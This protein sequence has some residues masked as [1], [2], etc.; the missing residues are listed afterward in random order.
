MGSE[1]VATR[2]AAGDR[3][4]FRRSGTRPTSIT[5]KHGVFGW[6]LYRAIV[7]NIH[8][9]PILEGAP[10]P[11][12]VRCSRRN[13]FGPHCSTIALNNVRR[14]ISSASEISACR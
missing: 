9:Q 5:S 8:L 7:C 13:L 2:L 12:R 6:S 11:A 1:V 10:S 3:R 4:R 14:A